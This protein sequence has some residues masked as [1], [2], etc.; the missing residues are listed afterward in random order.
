M[1]MIGETVK[2][3]AFGT[4]KIT[5]F[6]E[7]KITVMFDKCNDPKKFNFPEAIGTFIELENVKLYNEVI[8]AQVIFALKGAEQKRLMSKLG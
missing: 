6:S 7:E 2:H 8:E 4:G 5:D 1:K 3:K